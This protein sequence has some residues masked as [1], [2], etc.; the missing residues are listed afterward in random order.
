MATDQEKN[1][2]RDT[3]A[4]PN[5]ITNNK[6]ILLIKICQALA[7]GFCWAKNIGRTKDA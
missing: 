4:T 6:K 1:N 5:D 2:F 7:Y 3:S